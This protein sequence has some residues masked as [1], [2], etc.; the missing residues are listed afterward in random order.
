MKCRN[1]EQQ[2]QKRPALGFVTVREN[3]RW[4]EG[5]CSPQICVSLQKGEVN[6]AGNNSGTI[7]CSTLV[8]FCETVENSTYGNKLE[9]GRKKGA[10]DN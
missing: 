6:S 3:C 4:V 5:L 10:A 7:L 9:L 1:E 2:T 8:G